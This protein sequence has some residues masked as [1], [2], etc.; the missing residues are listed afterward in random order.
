MKKNIFLYT[1]IAVLTVALIGLGALN[2]RSLD[3][4][5]SL[6]NKVNELQKNV[7]EVSD[8]AAELS[9]KADQLDAL[10]PDNPTVTSAASAASEAQNDTK[11]NSQSADT[12]DSAASSDSADS[13]STTQE[14]G[15]LSPSSGSNTFTDNSDSS[16]DNLLNQV[17]SLLP[18]DNGTWSV[19]VCNLAK[20]TDGAINDQQ[21]QAASLIKLYI[22][23]AVYEDYDSLSSTYGKDT[24]DNALNS[25]ITVS[26]NNA[27]NTLVNY[28]GGG[29]GAAG[30]ARVNKFCQDHGY[31]STSMGRLLLADNSN[32]DNY[33]S[34]KDCGK[35]LKTIY[36][37]DKGV[38]TEDTLAGA[39]YMYHLL[40]MQTRTN[41]ITA[42][43]PDGVKVANKTGELDN[44]ENDAG[45]I[46]DTAKGIDLVVCFM[47]QDLN[48]TAAAQSVIA[49]DSRMIYGYY[50][51]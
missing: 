37:T 1:V 29:D 23:G 34:V 40:K 43:M 15:T 25:M 47:S 44:V 24:L 46:Y 27:A 38:S 48:D 5:A 32:G 6:Q 50:N 8:S 16:M 41:K 42:Q 12:Q 9:S 2:V 22:M 28:L 31:T 20:N 36:Q 7:Q 33:T 49:Q 18:T 11:D 10:Y 35:F 4:L 13:S 26:D 39:E 30:M 19:Y 3:K 51:E 45:I 21:M 14:E 17:Q